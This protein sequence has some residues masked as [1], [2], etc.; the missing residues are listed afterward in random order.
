MQPREV[1]NINLQICKN[2]GNCQNENCDLIWG[3]CGPTTKWLITFHVKKAI[4]IENKFWQSEDVPRSKHFPPL[5]Q[6]PVS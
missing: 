2:Q 6:K 1:E 5:L 3:V 4:K